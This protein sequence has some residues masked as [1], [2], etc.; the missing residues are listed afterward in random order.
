MSRSLSLFIMVDACG[1]EIVKNDP[2]LHRIAPHRTKLESVFGYSSTCVPSIVSGRWPDE[3]R[4]WCYF[5]HDPVQSPFRF[6]KWL[7]WLPKALTSRRIVRRALTRLVKAKLG[8]KGYFDLYN[9][10]FQHID[11]FDFT[12]KKS[13]LQA[14]GMN[15]GS[16]IFDTLKE[17]GTPHFISDPNQSEEANRD[18]LAAELRTGR[19]DFGFM[20]WA[21]LD[22]LLHRVGNDSPE[23]PAKLRVY[24]QWIADLQAAAQPH[25]DQVKLYVFSDHGMA[26]CD[27]HLDLKATIEALPLQFGKDYSVVYDSTIARFWFFNEAARQQITSALQAV[28][29]GRILPTAELKQLRTHFADHAFGELI[30]LV[31]E[32]VLIV[33]SHMGERPIRAMHGYHPTDPHSYA[34][35]FTNQATLPAEVTHIPHLHRLMI[36]SLNA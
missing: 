8:F 25:Y 14:G 28:P 18:A 35:L 33:P 36:H 13:P 32:G 31:Q 29:Q 34:T 6:L 19:I 4:N 17:K 5:V 26:N 24:E 23:V 21:G 16:N 3:H 1:W 12:E 30:F 11:Q 27:V 22:G 20:Y 15:C 7:R 10:P 9:I 2:F